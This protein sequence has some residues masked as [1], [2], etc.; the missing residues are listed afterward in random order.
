MWSPCDAPVI[1]NYELR[2]TTR[3]VER[4]YKAMRQRL[5]E[6]GY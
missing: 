1:A 4:V 5:V 3:D 2:G 6:A